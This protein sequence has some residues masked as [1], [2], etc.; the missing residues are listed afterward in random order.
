[1]GKAKQLWAKAGEWKRVEAQKEERAMGKVRLGLVGLGFGRNYVQTLAAA[2][3]IEGLQDLALTAVAERTKER[4]QG[5]VMEEI[6]K[7]GAKVYK[8][9]ASMVEGEQLGG[10]ILAVS[11]KFRA[12]VMTVAAEA[13][14]PM[15][16]EKP[17]AGSVEHGLQLKGIAAKHQAIVMTGFC[18]RY[19]PAMVKLRE[20]LDGE[21]GAG[22]L[23]SGEL[24]MSWCPGA[25]KHWMWDELG[26]GFFNENTVHLFDGICY[27]MGKPVAVHAEGR[28]FRSSPRADGAVL[29]ISFEN[30]SAACLMCGGVGSAGFDQEPRLNVVTE[31][32]QAILSG[33]D[34]M[35]DTVRWSARDASNV[36]SF[37]S[38]RPPKPSIVRYSLA[39]FGE[40]VR[41]GA[42]PTC[43]I[44]EGLTAT[45]LAM[46]T[47]ESIEKGKT[48][49][50]RAQ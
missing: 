16:V 31:N 23:V 48:V 14:L 41:T 46:A 20:L 1:V 28:A 6:E 34:H 42:K 25:G 15:L 9:C 45:A 8:D 37:S 5:P 33:A 35:W 17:F 3:E 44:E 27:L 21:L 2:A 13:G 30:G 43:G 29:T 36:Q 4:L 40:C 32:G 19:F 12:E 18:M 47:Y 26:G 50:V 49:R 7:T 22:W 24:T 39:H 11:P 10:I 38:E